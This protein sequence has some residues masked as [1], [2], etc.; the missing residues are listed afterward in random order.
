VWAE[1]GGV[2]RVLNVLEKKILPVSREVIA[3]A[4]KL[5]PTING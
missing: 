1:Y 4:W 3:N 2:M 5:L